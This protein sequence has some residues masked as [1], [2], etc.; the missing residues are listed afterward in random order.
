MHPADTTIN[1]YVFSTTV[2]SPTAD[3]D[4]MTIVFDNNGGSNY[5][6]TVLPGTAQDGDW[7][8][9]STWTEGVPATDDNVIISHDVTVNTSAV[10]IN[11]IIINDTASLEFSGG[12]N[13]II[14]GSIIVNGDAI[15]SN[16]SQINIEGLI[17]SPNN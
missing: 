6:Y 2:N 15:I 10:E 3:F 17:I 8:S 7:H 14:H 1:Y 13:H 16:S 12:Y 11:N 9:A 5:T 4:L